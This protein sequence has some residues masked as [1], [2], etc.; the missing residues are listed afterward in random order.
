MNFG[1]N[2]AVLLGSL[3]GSGGLPL[4]NT[5]GLALALTVGNNNTNTTFSGALS[6]S[7][8]VTLAGSGTWTLTGSNSYTGGTSIASGLLA[9]ENTATLPSGSLLSIGPSGAVVLGASGYAEAGLISG[10]GPLADS[11]PLAFSGRSVHDQASPGA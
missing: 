9:V 3:Q 7:G 2:T 10:G 11:A 5:A 4:A 6:G 1:S 8:S